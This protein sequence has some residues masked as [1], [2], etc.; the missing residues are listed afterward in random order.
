MGEEILDHM[1]DKA[2]WRSRQIGE[3]IVAKYGLLR[4]SGL[5]K[6]AEWFPNPTGTWSERKV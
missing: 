5:R 4:R 1:A 3:L 6:F 2:E